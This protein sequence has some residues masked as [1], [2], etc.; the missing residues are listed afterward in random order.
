MRNQWLTNIVPKP[1]IYRFLFINI[2]T[3]EELAPSHAG[4][5][6]IR[7]AYMDIKLVH[8]FPIK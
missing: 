8:L 3:T 5:A 1:Y 4:Y 2:L 6:K 7:N